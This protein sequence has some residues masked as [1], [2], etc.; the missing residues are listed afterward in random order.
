V[1]TGT[2]TITVRNFKVCHPRLCVTNEREGNVVN[3]HN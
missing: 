3:Q 2:G 1:A